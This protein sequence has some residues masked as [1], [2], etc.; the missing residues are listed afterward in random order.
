[1]GWVSLVTI[2]EMLLKFYTKHIKT[3]TDYGN[4]IYGTANRTEIKKLGPLQNKALRIATSHLKLM[5]II[6]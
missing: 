6:A 1:M 4:T 5:P 3:K 2:T